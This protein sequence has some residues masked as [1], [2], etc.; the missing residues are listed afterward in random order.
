MDLGC[1]ASGAM[2]A[3]QRHAGTA[4]ISHKVFIRSFCKSQLPQKSVNLFL[5]VV[6]I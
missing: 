3:R 1:T 6:M 2:F 4:L 5:I